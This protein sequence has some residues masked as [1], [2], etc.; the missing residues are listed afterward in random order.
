M[1]LHPSPGASIDPAGSP[2]RLSFDGLIDIALPR[3]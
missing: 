3:A 1:T 2:P